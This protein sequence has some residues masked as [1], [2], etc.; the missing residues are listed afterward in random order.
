M[1]QREK[2]D[3]RSSRRGPARQA[4]L[5]GWL[6][7]CQDKVQQKDRGEVAAGLPRE[8]VA[9]RR[10]RRRRRRRRSSKVSGSQ[11]REALHI[12]HFI[13]EPEISA[14]PR[15]FSEA[16]RRCSPERKKY[17][18]WICAT[19]EAGQVSVLVQLNRAKE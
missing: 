12:K 3:M 17:E 18:V 10:W 7:P 14:E 15:D 16:K 8:H 13:S 4:G 1:L 5:Q 11:T 2:E 19:Q 6:F 9:R